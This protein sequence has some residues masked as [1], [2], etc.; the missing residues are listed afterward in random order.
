MKTITVN[1]YEI[2]DIVQ[3][4][5]DE[6]LPIGRI[7]KFDSSNPDFTYFVKTFHPE[8]YP[9]KDDDIETER[10]LGTKVVPERVRFGWLSDDG[11]FS[12]ATEKDAAQF[13]KDEVITDEEMREAITE[14]LK[15]EI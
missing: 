1:I 12:L 6:D 5:W 3:F 15:K 10:I 11:I 2:G 4:K 9:I 14:S 7:I 13:L 8:C